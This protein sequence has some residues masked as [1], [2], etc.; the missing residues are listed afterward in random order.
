[1]KNRYWTVIL[2][3]A[4]LSSCIIDGGEG[5][6]VDLTM[7]NQGNVVLDLSDIDYYDF[8]SHIVYLK[9]SN[10]LEGDFDQLRGAKILVNGTEIYPLNIHDLYL[11]TMP[12]GPHIQSLIDVFGDFA[13]RISFSDYPDGSGSSI[14]DPRSDARIVSALKKH[15]KYRAGLSIEAESILRQGNQIKLKIKI[16]N[17]DS[18]N[19]YFLDPHKM[20]EGLFHYFTNGLGFF[21]PQQMG[22]QQNKIEHEPPEPHLYWSLD[23]MSVIKG[24]ES[25]TFEFTYPFENVPTGRDLKFSFVFPS[26]ERSIQLGSDLDQQ[27]GRIWLGSVIMELTKRF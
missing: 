19:Y 26:P 7:V 21:D 5:T 18:Q 24:K 9:G 3:S 15:N 23:W 25:K 20:G 1:M 12:V 17:L 11:S 14:K 22:Y 10:R 27:G 8:S 16:R 13:F 4:L 2:F 6:P